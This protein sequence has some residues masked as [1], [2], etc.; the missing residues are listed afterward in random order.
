M[1]AQVLPNFIH[2]YLLRTLL[3][4]ITSSNV[5]VFADTNTWQ[6]SFTPYLWNVSFDGRTSSGGSDVP[7]DIDYSFFTLD[8]LDNVLSGNF[9][10]SN[11][12]H[13]VFID[14]LCARYS[15]EFARN[16]VNTNL[17][18]ELGYIEAAYLYSPFAYD[19]LGLLAGARY[20][21][22]E[23]GLEFTPGPSTDEK[24]EWVDP[25]LGVEYSDEF[26]HGWYYLLRGDLGGFGVS[27]D[28]VINLVVTLG[29]S[30]N[31]TIS[32]EAGYRYLAV[33]FKEE[34]FLYDVS[35][36]GV[37]VGLGIHF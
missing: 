24:H 28:L 20:L 22:V 5:A 15:D 25:L 14:A 32:L 30:F 33:D 11:G 6:Y 7:I 27:S 29:Y 17:W 23:L 1:T 2:K 12:R 21:F 26:R 13:G 10:A 34:D 8:N 4:C 3:L 37:V 9:K 19:N 31:R 18:S 16:L 36:Q 35:I